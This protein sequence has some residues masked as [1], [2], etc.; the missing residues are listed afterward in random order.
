MKKILITTLMGI[1]LLIGT[2]ANAQIKKSTEPVKKE[3]ADKKDLKD[4]KQSNSA[5][6]HHD[7]TEECQN[8]KGHKECDRHAKD[9]RHH[10]CSGE[11]QEK[12]RTH[13]KDQK[14]CDRQGN[15][16]HHHECAGA[17]DDKGHKG[18]SCNNCEDNATKKHHHHKGHKD[19]KNAK[20]GECP[21]G[22][23]R[24]TKEAT[25]KNDNKERKV[26]TKKDAA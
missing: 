18:K 8:H 14:E 3:Q 1:G 2:T 21:F 25:K 24:K 5:K 10:D 9:K 20:K 4:Q 23:T 26:E 6:H 17:C 22:H 11:C 7:C 12:G 13:H 15:G 19:Y 16:K